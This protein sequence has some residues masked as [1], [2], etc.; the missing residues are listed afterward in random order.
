ML[1]LP[2][3]GKF[4]RVCRGKP[5]NNTGKINYLGDIT[6]EEDKKE[7]KPEEIH[8]ITQENKITMLITAWK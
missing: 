3:K 8:Q 5:S 7:S 4:A 2:K 6:S 1:K